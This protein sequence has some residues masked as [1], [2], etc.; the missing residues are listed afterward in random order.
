MIKE[1]DYL[2]KKK[3]PLTTQGN[4]EYSSQQLIDAVNYDGG[5]RFVQGGGKLDARGNAVQ[6][7]LEKKL[8]RNF[9]KDVKNIK[10]YN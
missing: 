8:G 1:K 4:L 5:V 7:E 2:N 3:F 6:K 10:G 9:A